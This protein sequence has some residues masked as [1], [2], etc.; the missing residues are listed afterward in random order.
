MTCGNHA[1]NNYDLA[2]ITGCSVSDLLITSADLWCTMIQWHSSFIGIV[3]TV[4]RIHQIIFIQC[5]LK[6]I[7]VLIH[8]SSSS[9]FSYWQLG[10]LYAGRA[11]VVSS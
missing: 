10:L 1:A 2:S 3:D 9:P 5:I 4:G 7:K 8:P 6:L 11:V